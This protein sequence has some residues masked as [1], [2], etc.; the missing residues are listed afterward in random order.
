M[1]PLD[2]NSNNRLEIELLKKDMASIISLFNKMEDSVDKIESAADELSKLLMRQDQKL[3]KEIQIV[4]DQKFK[5]DEHTRNSHERFIMLNGKIENVELKIEKIHQ[6]ILKKIEESHDK[7]TRTIFSGRNTL[8][9]Q[10]DTINKT[11][12]EKIV[13][14]DTW[15]YMV[16]G[17]IAFVVFILSNITGITTIVTKLFR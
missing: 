4:E 10:V 5:F 2:T 8:Q 9:T 11:L 17:G 16:M 1:P 7:T 13:A 12:S 3:E 6:E 14:I 15:R